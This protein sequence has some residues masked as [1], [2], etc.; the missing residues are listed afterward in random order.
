MALTASQ[1]FAHLNPAGYRSFAAAL[2]HPLSGAD[3]ILAMVAVGLW[4]AMPDGRARL[5]VP[6]AFVGVMLLGFVAT[7]AG[8]QVPFVEPVIFAS[9][10]S[11]GSRE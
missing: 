9:V 3:H 8:L 6:A 7:I 1:A 2:T 4:A 10:V 5:S 11:A